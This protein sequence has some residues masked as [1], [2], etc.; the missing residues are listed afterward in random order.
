MHA[1]GMD[2]KLDWSLPGLSYC[3]CFIYVP[4]FLLDMNNSGSGW[5]VDGPITAVGPC[6]TTG[7]GISASISPLFGFSDKV[8]PFEFLE[9]L[10]SLVSRNF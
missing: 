2:H 3:L 7:D 10:I 5:K 9:L 8:I 6:L 4:A 1:H